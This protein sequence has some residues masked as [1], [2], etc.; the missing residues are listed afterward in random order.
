MQEPGRVYFLT[1]RCRPGIKLSPPERTMVLEALRHWDEVKWKVFVV[2]V[3]LDHVHALVQALT[4]PA[5]GTYHLAEILHSVKSY[6]S[7]KIG[8]SRGL[9][10]SLW[11]DESYDPIV[12]DEAE[13]LEKWQYIR[14]NPLK[15]SLA[16]KP[17]NYTWLYERGA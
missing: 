14:N 12:R 13:F 2:V 5:G 17:E 3:L 4:H 9:K 1:W 15:A 8:T 11:Q 10:G 7:H 6:T 16:D